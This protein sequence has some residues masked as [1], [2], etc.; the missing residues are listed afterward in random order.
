MPFRGAHWYLLLLVPLIG[1]AF[2]PGYFA[3]FSSAPRELHI[4]GAT[5]SLWI[6]L[7]VTQ[8]WSI[9][10]RR[11][12]LH[13]A[14]GASSFVLFPLFVMGGVLVIR[15]MAVKYTSGLDPFYAVNGPQLAAI[16]TLATVSILILVHQAMRY[17]RDVHR[18]AAAMLGTVLF[19]LGPIL[20]RFLAFLPPFAITG[21]EDFAGFGVNVHLSHLIGAGVAVA[22]AVR[23]PRSRQPLLILAGLVLLQSLAFELGRTAAWRQLVSAIAD[24]PPMLLASAGFG[25]GLAALWTGW[26]MVPPRRPPMVA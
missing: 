14:I 18:H 21:P 4:H 3:A 6:A 16:D 13:R 20:A 25:L 15:S 24:V 23:H 7:L 11:A 12:A 5:A 17:R 22:M 2:W 10:H 26:R 9:H 1:L 8:S 19:L